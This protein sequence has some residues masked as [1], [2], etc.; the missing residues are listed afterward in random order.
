MRIRT[1][2]IATAATAALI[3]GTALLPTAANADAPD[4]TYDV[5][6][7]AN[8]NA[9]QIGKQ[10]SAIKQNGQFVSGNGDNLSIPDQT[11]SPGSR[12]ALVQFALGH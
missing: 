11:T 3:G 4:G 9:S 8:D 2:L 1:L 5:V 12:A 6:V 10:S 7:K